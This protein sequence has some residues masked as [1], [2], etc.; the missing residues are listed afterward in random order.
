MTHYRLNT[1]DVVIRIG[2]IEGLSGMA[3]P[4]PPP[5]ESKPFVAIRLKFFRFVW[6]YGIDNLR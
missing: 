1:F 2:Q 4:G 3:L 5:S 6:I